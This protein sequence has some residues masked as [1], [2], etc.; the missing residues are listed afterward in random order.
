MNQKQLLIIAIICILAVIA[1]LTSYMLVNSQPETFTTLRISESCTVE[2]PNANNTVENINGVKTYSFDTVSLNISHEKSENNSEIKDLNSK[3][4][5][6]SENVEGNIYYDSSTGIYSTF[7]ENND[8]GDALLITSDN[9]NLIKRVS[10]SVKFKNPKII[11]TGND[12]NITEEIDDGE[13]V[14]QYSYDEGYYSQ[15]DYQPYYPPSDRGSSDS[16]P[17][18]NSSK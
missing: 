15:N 17:A 11:D 18:D 6:N 3:Q 12:T 10:N 8:T 16:T 9:L 14:E 4:I 1:C 13:F 5:K 2:V 7:I